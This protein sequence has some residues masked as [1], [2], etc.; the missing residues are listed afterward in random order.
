MSRRSRQNRQAMLQL[1]SRPQ[2]P[3]LQLD[4][5]LYLKQSPLPEFHLFKLVPKLV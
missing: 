2:N 1:L 3:D 4:R 5:A